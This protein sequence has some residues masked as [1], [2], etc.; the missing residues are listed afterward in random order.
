LSLHLGLARRLN[1]RRSR[2]G[3]EQG[4][5][6][7]FAAQFAQAAAG[8]KDNRGA[9]SPGTNPATGARA[10]INRRARHAALAAE[11]PP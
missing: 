3:S 5:D 2:F 11:Q 6:R 1:S 4:G 7:R 10:G 8:G 9:A